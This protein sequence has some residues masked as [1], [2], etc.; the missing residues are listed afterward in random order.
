[1][2]IILATGVELAP[3]MVTGATKYVQGVNRDSLTFIFDE[4][5]SMDELDNA[6]T[7]ASFESIK[8]IGDD[9]SEAIYTGYT[10]YAELAKKQVE[11]Q[12]ATDS[13]AAVF[14]NRIFVTM[15]QRTYTET[16]LAAVAQGSIDTQL[17]VAELAELVVGG[18][19][20]G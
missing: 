5:Y 3:I 13:I 12:T 20:N 1:M 10:I 9:G 11:T 4:S 2:K 6:F 16:K 15:A 8:I 18:A 14:E 7:E 19:N 17:A